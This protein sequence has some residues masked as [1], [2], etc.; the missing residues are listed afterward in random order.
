MDWC[1]VRNSSQGKAINSETH[2]EEW[3]MGGI[4]WLL[5]NV[6]DRLVVFGPICDAQRYLSQTVERL[7]MVWR[8]PLPRNFKP[9]VQGFAR[10]V[11]SLVQGALPAESVLQ[12]QARP[13]R[14]FK[15]ALDNKLLEFAAQLRQNQRNG[16]PYIEA[17]DLCHLVAEFDH[18]SGAVLSH[19]LPY[20]S[21]PS[22]ARR[23][24]FSDNAKDV[25]LVAHVADNGL[26]FHVSV[27]S[28]FALNVGLTSGPLIVTCAH[29]L[30]EVH[31]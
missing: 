3:A 31:L 22:A 27:S 9:G 18:R 1:V 26:D 10:V 20:E 13:G 8:K 14:Q 15:S 11:P 23:I 28:G 6:G 30:E 21:R 5:L 29:T 4:S 19:E 25:F 17:P 7:D 12:T 16:Q 24:S 2:R